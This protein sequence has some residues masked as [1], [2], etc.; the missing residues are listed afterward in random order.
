MSATR[1]KS[2]VM[3][4]IDSYD[5][6]WVLG[7]QM[8]SDFNGCSPKGGYVKDCGMCREVEK[9]SCGEWLQ[10]GHMSRIS[11]YMIGL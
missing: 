5:S 4:F 9:V 7:F 8:L 1:T 2:S 10:S 3:L 11:L 6:F